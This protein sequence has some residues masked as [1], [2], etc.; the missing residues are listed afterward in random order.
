M[1]LERSV[2]ILY[3][4]DDPGAARLFQRRL[5][6]I[7][8]NVDLAGDGEE[9]LTKWL[10]GSYDVLA[11]DHDMPKKRGIELLHELASMGPLPPTLMITGQGNETVAVEAMKLG[12][13]DYI[14]KDAEARYLDLIPQK[15]EESLADRRAR[16]HNRLM[17]EA[18]G[19]QRNLL[20]AVF[21]TSPYIMM[22]V[23]REGRVEMIN[24]AGIN[25]GDRPEEELLGRLGGEVFRCMNSFEGLGCGRNPECSLCPV[26]SRVM[27]SLQTGEAI[28]EEEG[29]LTVRR[30]SRDSRRSLLIS[31]APVKV[32]GKEMVLV[33]LADQTERKKAEEAVHRERQIFR[34]ILETALAGYWDWDIPED[35]GYLSLKFKETLG[36][37]DDEAPNSSDAWRLLIFEE[38]LAVAR[39]LFDE[40][41]KSGGRGPFSVELRYKRKDGGALWALCVGR[42]VEWNDR[43]DPLRMVGCH[44]D[45]TERKLA[46]RQVQTSRQEKEALLRGTHHRIKNNLAFVNSLLSIQSGYSEGRSGEELFQEIR[47]RI[48]S[49]ALAHEILYQSEDLYRLPIINY[50]MP[51]LNQVLSSHRGAKQEITLEND[52]GELECSL[53]VALP[54]GFILTELV[55]N[56]L[57]HAFPNGTEGSI[58]VSLQAVD[59][60]WLKLTVA[61]NGVGMP[62]DVELDSPRSMG[63]DLVKTFVDQL[64]GSIEIESSRGTKV[65]AL[66]KR[67]D[68]M[69]K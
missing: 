9:G 45:I 15:I 59:S 65:T 30:G 63:L 19:S 67:I 53:D 7:G 54:I 55:S 31:T 56:S 48:R 3:V 50:L 10:A 17:E 68:D 28:Y 26:R 6:R 35:K 52:I 49:I 47:S 1:V 24:R 62:D 22:V 8:Y 27:R 57:R 34:E 18:L 25:L 23:N 12:A 20:A 21:E 46:E 32:G 66:L 11:L 13:D 60:G 29:A 69:S 39:K 36:Y 42:V 64:E 61:D 33:T 44:V 37:Q 5:T 4:E 58:R 16:E 38:D 51:L 43:G 14:M 2:R 41:V 40:H